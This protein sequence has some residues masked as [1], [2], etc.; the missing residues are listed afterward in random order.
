MF[1]ISTELPPIAGHG[2]W[3]TST[4]QLT[5]LWSGR[6]SAGHFLTFKCPSPLVGGAPCW[7]SEVA[8]FLWSCSSLCFLWY[9]KG[10]V[11]RRTRVKWFLYPVE[12]N[13]LGSFVTFSCK[14]VTW[15]WKKHSVHLSWG[16][17]LNYLASCS[18]WSYF[19]WLVVGFFS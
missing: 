13:S 17:I 9:R 4:E 3:A 2:V 12:G 16:R 8:K 6:S 18:V 19:S 1:F 5:R 15:M 14:S 10:E 11:T 7:I